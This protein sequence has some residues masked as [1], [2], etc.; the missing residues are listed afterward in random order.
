MIYTT[1]YVESYYRQLKKV[2]KAKSIFFNDQALLKMLYLAT[3]DASGRWTASVRDWPLILSKLTVYFKER[4]S[5]YV[6]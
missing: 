4:V 2:T 5:I 3:M 1:N 6:I